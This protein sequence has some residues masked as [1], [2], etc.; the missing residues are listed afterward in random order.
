MKRINIANSSKEEKDAALNE[1]RLLA[2]LRHI[3]IIGYKEAFYDIPSNT[4]NVIIEYADGGDLQKRIRINKQQHC[5]F[6]E[7]FI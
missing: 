5:L 6:S 1:I 4:L 3:N 7:D 2:S